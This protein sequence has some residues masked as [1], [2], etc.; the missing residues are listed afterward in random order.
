MLMTCYAT[1][2][3]SVQFAVY[4]VQCVVCSVSL[5]VSV[6]SVQCE[7]CHCVFQ[8]AVCHCVFQCSVQQCCQAEEHLLAGEAL[9]GE[10]GQGSLHLDIRPGA[11]DVTN[12]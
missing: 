7:V 8:C 2:L 11:S 3:Y 10:E 4:S 5:C 9:A 1:V 12:P 6:C